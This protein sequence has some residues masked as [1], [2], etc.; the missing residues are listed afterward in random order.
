[1]SSEREH[2]GSRIAVILA[3]AGSAIGLGNIWRFP[4]MVGEYG[5]AVFVLIYVL[6]SFIL[7]LPI[8]LAE[9]LIGRRSRRNAIGAMACLAPRSGWTVFGY[10]S[11]IT[12]VVILSYYSI[13]GG[14]SLEYLLKGFSLDFGTF[15]PS[16][17]SP[18]LYGTLF[19]AASCAIVAFGVKKGI[20]R[21]S[22]V[23]I[24]VLFVMILVVT[25]YSIRMPGADKGVAYLVHPEFSKL[26]AST[27]AYA[28]GQSFY[29]ISLGMGIVLTYSSYVKKEENLVASG[30]G[31]ALADLVFALLAAFAIM[32]A[33]FAS[34]LEPGSGPGLVFETLPNVFSDMGA[35]APWVGILVSSLFFLTLI[36]AA[37]TSAISLA[38]VAT[39]YLIENWH[40]RRG[41]ACLVVFAAEWLLG[42]G[43]AFSIKFFGA[44]DAFS[45]NFLLTLG[46]LLAVLFVGWKMKRADVQ[47]ELTNGGTRNQALF[48]FLYFLIR[49]A[50]PV[51]VLAIFVSNLV[52]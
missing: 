17:W 52:L 12:P 27:F 50:A 34:G 10:L 28:L 45:S 14:W 21:F 49:W 36:V 1:M 41:V 43:S 51:A 23:S 16:G 13:V 40:L 32:P 6:C 37:M 39:A 18:L 5:G 7:A 48:P 42:V 4:Y 33:V 15:V 11:V 47:D 30:A 38:E 24:P 31:T 44:V 20:E 8:F 3:M 26:T 29:S 22:K 35:T 2:F 25:V 9:A 19:L 46:A